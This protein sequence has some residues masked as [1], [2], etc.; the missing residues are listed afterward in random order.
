MTICLQ[1][2][3]AELFLRKYFLLWRLFPR[4]DWVIIFTWLAGLAGGGGGGGGGG[5]GAG[6]VAAD[7]DILPW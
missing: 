4:H 5:A 3:T 2:K 6:G 1:V 7:Q